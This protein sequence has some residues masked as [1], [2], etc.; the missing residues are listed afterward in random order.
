VPDPTRWFDADLLARVAAYRGPTR[1][2]V[3]ASLLIEVVVPLAVAYTAAGARIVERIVGAV[4]RHRPVMGAT[5]VVVV[6]LVV[7]AL[8]R[9]P[10]SAWAYTRARAVGLSVQSPWSWLGEWAI[11]RG[12]ELAVAAVITI[13]GYVLLRRWARRWALLAAPMGVVVVALAVLTGPVLLEPLRF[14][15]VPLDD[16]PLRQRLER[17]VDAADRSGA[18]LLVADAS[19][20]TTRQNAYVSGLWGTRRIVLYDTLL[21]RPPDEIAAVLAHELAHDRHHDLLRGVAGGAAGWVVACLALDAVLRR[22]VRAGRLTSVADPR[23]AATALAVVVLL[24]ALSTPVV[25]WASRRAEAAADMGALELTG[26]PQSF[27][28]LQRGFV[29]RNLT[30]PAPPAWS[31]WWW[32]THPPAASRLALAARTDPSPPC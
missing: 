6:V 31:R 3:A 23:G 11:A 29:E 22:R 21:E 15:T 25:S 20:K 32:G 18:R 19:E 2:I 24:T 26:D 30:D 16:G 12:V 27:C 4:G 7:T 5:A 17:V 14:D 28:G 9:L 1:L 8:C 10:L 13:G